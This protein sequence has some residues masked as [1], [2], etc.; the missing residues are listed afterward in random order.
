MAVPVWLPYCGEAP[1]P[2]VWL[3]RWNF[4]P[5][6]LAGLGVLAVLT[7]LPRGPWAGAGRR[8]AAMQGALAF[9]ALLYVSPLCA[10]SSAF[11][12]VRV[13]H[14]VALVLAL[15][16]LAAV[17]LEPWLARGARHLWG[18][19]AIAAATFWLWHS[20]GAY[21][22]A[23]TTSAVYWLMQAS[24]LVTAVLFWAAVR[25][26]PPGIA[27]AAVLATTVQMGLLGALITFATRPLYPPHFLSAASWGV[28][29]LYDQQLAGVVMWAPGSFAYLAVAM[30]IGWRWLRESAAERVSAV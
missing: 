28:S 7:V 6:L 26:A 12:S 27:I 9:A 10:L 21:S 8:R 29:P 25:R 15:A 19:T 20:P 18:W 17:A 3:A 1:G 5:A 16:P 24:L 30:I 14:H 22:L 4:D 11:F 13:V 2:A 23:L